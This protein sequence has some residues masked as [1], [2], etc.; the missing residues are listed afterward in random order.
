MQPK[1]DGPDP[2]REGTGVV[3]HLLREAR[4]PFLCASI[5][6]TVE[7]AD[8]LRMHE[9]TESIEVE[10]MRRHAQSEEK[11]RNLREEILHL[12]R[13]IQEARKCQTVADVVRNTVAT[14]ID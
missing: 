4:A 2:Q 11:L 7:A 6:E 3:L 14:Y 9:F 1:Q 10:G 8:D 12:K 5:Q 13:M